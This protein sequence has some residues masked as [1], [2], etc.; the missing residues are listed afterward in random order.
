MVLPVLVAIFSLV[1]ILIPPHYRDTQGLAMSEMSGLIQKRCI[2]TA[3]DN[4]RNTGYIF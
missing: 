1:S 2:T 3:L 4:S